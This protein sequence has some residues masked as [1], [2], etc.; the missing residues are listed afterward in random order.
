[1]L[2]AGEIVGPYTLTSKLGQGSFGVVWL[3]ERRTA[4]AVTKVALKIPLDDE[5]ELEA[6]R[7][8]AA[9]WAMA[10][11]HPNV[12]PIIEAD[13]YGGRVVIASEYAPDGSLESWLRKHGGRAPSIESAV[14]MTIG[15][16]AGLEHLH[17]RRII[18]RD[19][20]PANILLQGEVPRLADFGI[21]RVL[22]STSQSNI[23]AGTPVYMAPEA[24]DRK[25]NEQT[26]LWSAGVMLYQMIS[27]NLPFPHSDMASLIGAIVT[28]AP[29]PLPSD[30]G[31]PVAEIIARA[32]EKS[33]AAR[34]KS[35]GEM[36][37]AL[38]R[39]AIGSPAAMTEKHSAPPTLLSSPVAPT[40]P[41]PQIPAQQVSVPQSGQFASSSSGASVSSAQG[42][43]PHYLYAAVAMIAVL[44]LGGI[45]SVIAY[46]RF[47]PEEAPAANV[48]LPP[49]ASSE[50]R[51]GI[52]PVPAAPVDSYSNLPGRES[53][54]GGA[55]APGGPSDLTPFQEVE[56]KILADRLLTVEDLEGFTREEL[57][58]LRNTIYARHGRVFQSPDLQWYFERRSWYAPRPAYTDSALTENDRAN[59]KLILH[60]EGP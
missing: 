41:S 25:R 55:G 20:K 43:P 42:I 28:K 34:Y 33:P 45:I 22:K 58:L 10:S 14:E 9:L 21:S 38:R 27:G 37:A 18:H 36:R 8:E 24:F 13:V 29:E 52:S 15:I 23:M 32:L 50:A 46:L 19:L 57:R 39:A 48:T 17:S 51:P 44:F 7:Q 56:A 2:R 47:R 12:L 3:A 4:I 40:Q 5:I 1:M 11:G 54:P 6:I 49:Q 53:R 31:G 16:L 59:G 26:D 30:A 60:V 35:A